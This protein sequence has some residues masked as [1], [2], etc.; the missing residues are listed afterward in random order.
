MTLGTTDNPL[1]VA[2]VGSGPAGF[3]A[4]EAL[5]KREGVEVD[6][7]DRLPTPYGL[8]RLGVAPDH[9]KIK[10]VIRIYEK[11]AAQPGFRFFGNVNVGGDVSIAELA[12]RYHAVVYAYGAETDRHLGIPGEDL[13]GS[14][15][16]TAFVAWYNG[17]PDYAGAEFD[18]SHERAVVVGNGNVAMDVARMLALTQEELATTDTADHAIEALGRSNVREIVVLGRRGPA[19]AA[20]TNPEVKELGEMVDADCIVDPAEVELDPTSAAYL[21][22]EASDKTHRVNVDILREFASR[23]PESLGKRKRIVLRFL[24][25]P[26]EIQGEGKVERVVIGRNRLEAEHD[27]RIRAVDTGE[28]ETIEAG[29]LLRSVGYKGVPLENLPFDE[30]RGTIPNENGRVLDPETGGQ[31]AGHY[32]VG[33]IKRGPSGVIGTNKKDAQDTVASVLEDLDAGRIP[34]REARGDVT[35]LLAE[36]DVEFVSFAGWQA[37]DRA[38]VSRGEPQGRPRVKFTSVAEMLEVAAR[39]DAVVG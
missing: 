31:M 13:P 17:H 39:E 16:A 29:L 19:Q 37:I 21:E 9:P 12:E 22:S 8:V 34:Q 14:H 15:P 30:G 36:R 18:L 10:S 25:S 23:Q 28:R 32:V 35:D 20:F 2:I 4:A 24:C 1:R 5:L 6:V 27:G 33:W 3:Y 7:F 26:V 11:T 38:E